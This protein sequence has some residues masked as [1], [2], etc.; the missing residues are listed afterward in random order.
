MISLEK[1]PG[2][3]FIILNLTDPQLAD[4][5]WAEGHM[6]R[7]IL[8][9]TVTELV[10]R[11]KP[12][13]ITITGDIAWAGHFESYENFANLLDSFEIPWAPIWGNHDNQ[14]GPESV[15]R[16]VEG[17]LKHKYCIYERGDAGLGNG[18]YVI[19][20]EENGKPVEGLIMMDTHDRISYMDDNG[21][22]RKAYAIL[23]PE[24]VE[25]YKGQVQE[26]K[27]R[28]C[29]DTTMMLHIPI[30]A[31]KEA[32]EAAFCKKFEREKI[33]ILDYFH[34]NCW[35]DGYKDTIGIQLEDVA[36]SV[37]NDRVMDAVVEMGSTKHIVAGHDHVNNWMISYRGVRLLY[38]LKTGAGCYWNPYLNGGTVFRVT[39]EGVENV[40]HEYVHL[41]I[42]D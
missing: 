12:D 15:E 20:I 19:S 26:L 8:V 18:N 35:N 30:Y 5:E 22:T 11:A 40:Y 9:H 41:G 25:W 7:K 37:I 6:N 27:S 17:Y 1:I 13:L 23:L 32:F 24:Q 14:D 36:C 4:D 28:G 34:E 16:V 21:E 2:K 3:D 31:Y 10:R 42:V 38:S 29:N 33:S 39:S